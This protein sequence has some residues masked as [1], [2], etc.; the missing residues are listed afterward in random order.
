[1]S[2]KMSYYNELREY[3]PKVLCKKAYR[4]KYYAENTDQVLAR[5]K[6]YR[7]KNVEILKTRRKRWYEINKEQV[8]S[9]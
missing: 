2:H 8:A 5:Q 1:M 9:S 3:T 4:K 6:R 7:A